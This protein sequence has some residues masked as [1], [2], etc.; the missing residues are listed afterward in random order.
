MMMYCIRGHISCVPKSCCL[1]RVLVFHTKS[2]ILSEFFVEKRSMHISRLYKK[3][4]KRVYRVII[5]LGLLQCHRKKGV[6]KWAQRTK[7]C[8]VYC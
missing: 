7:M 4:T 3:G 2:Y 5:D 1:K 8:A 6:V